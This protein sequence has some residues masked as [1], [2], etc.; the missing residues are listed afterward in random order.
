MNRR[1]FWELPLPSSSSSSMCISGMVVNLSDDVILFQQT[2][3]FYNYALLDGVQNM[4][5]KE[6]QGLAYCNVGDRCY[7]LGEFDQALRNHKLYLRTLG[8]G[9]IAE[10]MRACCSLGKDYHSLGDFQSAEY[11]YSL[12]RRFAAQMG[13]RAEE[14]RACEN[15]G[16]TSYSMDDFD[17]ASVWHQAALDIAEEI[18]DEAE[19]GKANRNLGN[20]RVGSSKYEDAIRHHRLDLSIVRKLA[21]KAGEG[22]AHGN[23]GN[24]YFNQGLVKK[25]IEFQKLNLNI[26]KE[27]G[28]IA[29]EGKAGYELGFSFESVGRLDEAL[30]CYQSSLKQFSKIRSGGQLN[31]DVKIN[32]QDEYQLVNIALC[33]VLLKQNKIV[34]AL[35]AAEEGRAP[36]LM[37]L[38]KSNYGTDQSGPDGQV[39]IPNMLSHLSSTT[40]FLALDKK[41]L[42][43]WVL[44]KGNDAVHFR[45][46]EIDE[47]LL[48]EDGTL[49]FDSLT[50]AVYPLTEDEIRS[51]ATYAFQAGQIRR[52]QPQ[53]T[54][55]ALRMLYD[56]V[57]RPVADLLQVDDLIIVPDGP[58]CVAPFAAFIDADSRHLC[59][60]FTIR[61]IPSLTSLKLIVDSSEYHSR[62]GALLVGN[63]YLEE[64]VFET[65]W[66]WKLPEAEKEVKLLGEMLNSEP[67]TG[68][69]AT[70]EE[71]LSRL[72]S[73]SDALVHIAAQGSDENGDIY[74]TPNPIRES[75]EPELEDYMLT[76]SDVI[77]LQLRA[78]LVVL[79]CCHSG[80][81]TIKGTE[82]AVGIGRAFVAAGARCVLVALWEIDDGATQ[83]FMKRFY[84]HL[85]A[86]KRASVA[87]NHAM[88]CVRDP[89]RLGDVKNWAAFQLIGDD[90]TLK[91]EEEE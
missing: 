8:V 65:P 11:C 52:Q 44:P 53:L 28:D 58:L 18:G 55:K 43:I 71:V 41:E 24:V 12:Q 6:K 70:K 47:R 85:L 48:E 17:S 29:E 56:V 10:K 20:C 74:L 38:M 3:G 2:C 40:V 82:G 39:D 57:F 90:I 63:P 88:K 4:G 30:D 78:L 67:L 19:I 9:D 7:N 31:D 15:L 21:D 27:V 5:N 54:E 49:S 89:Q 86:G 84:E 91:F 34:E 46:S 25:A 83:E 26:S 36:A 23:L 69:N 77:S 75:Q 22:A 14:G 80:Q 73:R 87:L 33:R 45:K 61:V 35:S 76:M 79:S 62:R 66:N 68:V 42:N 72:K 59:E 50:R 16:S 51:R 13:D 32:L 64:I 1:V 60:S 81:G 37:D